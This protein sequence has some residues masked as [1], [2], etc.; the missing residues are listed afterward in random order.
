MLPGF[1]TGFGHS[2]VG[3]GGDGNTYDIDLSQKI[4]Q[5][6]ERLCAVLTA[7]ERTPFLVVVEDTD[8]RRVGQR[9]IESCMMPT[10]MSDPDY[11][12]TKFGHIRL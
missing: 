3:R 12:G 10:E 6:A 7:D 9:G 8:Q 11:T 1:E 4:R 2:I 5:I